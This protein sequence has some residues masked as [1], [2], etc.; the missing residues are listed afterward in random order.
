M[1]L[2]SSLR[3]QR[4][5]IALMFGLLVVLLLGLLGLV[6]DLGQLYS[7]EQEMRTLADSTALA[8]ARE[9]NGTAT[10][11]NSALSHAAQTAVVSHYR[12]SQPVS[13]SSAALSFADDPDGPWHSAADT[14]ASPSGRLFARVDTRQLAEEHG[15]VAT[16]FLFLLAPAQASKQVAAVAVAGRSGLGI[17]PLAVCAMDPAPSKTRNIAGPVDELVQYGFRRGVSYNLLNL[18]PALG[19]G[20]GEYFLVDPVS[21]AGTMGTLANTEDSVLAPFMCAGRLHLR[22]IGSQPVTVRRKTPFTLALQLN[23]R[24]NSYG[25]AADPLSCTPLAAPPDS[26]VASFAAGSWMGVAPSASHAQPT[27]AGTPGKPLSTVADPMPEPV[28]NA[29]SYGPLWAYGPAVIS[30]SGAAYPRAYWPQLYPAS[31][32]APTA[33][34]YPA[35]SAPYAAMVTAPAGNVGV[36]RRRLLQIPLLACPVPAG[37][38]QQASV[39]AIGTF[40]MVAPASGAAISA[41]FAGLANEQSLG[42]P[43]ELLR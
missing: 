43:V 34:S 41:E 25:P 1:K 31:P 32:G 21:A 10:G 20:S 35:L 15:T 22:R 3:R 16:A 27:A 14:A 36:A 19:A 13:W 33:P 11:V 18:N 5:A 42:T 6:I 7:R 38:L 8:A 30:P 4:G 29:A 26:N 17:A 12:Y 24:F 39:L 2:R 9:L 28:V 37:Q 40:F 23:S